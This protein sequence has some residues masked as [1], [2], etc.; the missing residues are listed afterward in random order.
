MN[1]DPDLNPPAFDAATIAAVLTRVVPHWTRYAG[2]TIVVKYGG[3]AM[4]AG[5]G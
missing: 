3:H 4:G 5:G 2:K 1:A